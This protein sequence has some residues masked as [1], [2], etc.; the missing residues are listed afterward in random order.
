MYSGLM[1]Y[2]P[3][4]LAAVSHLSWRGNEQH[5]PGTPLHWDK[6][7]SADELDAL[8]RHLVDEEWVHVAWRALANLQRKLD[9]GWQPWAEEHRVSSDE[10]IRDLVSG[11]LHVMPHGGANKFKSGHNASDAALT[12]HNGVGEGDGGLS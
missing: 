12:S 3:S 2:F 8:M 4:A 5:H 7:K 6:S 11:G 1:A 9:A 10:Q